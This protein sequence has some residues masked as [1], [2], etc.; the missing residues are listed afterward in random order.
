V[1]ATQGG[2]LVG[3]V[4]D[5]G[6][7]KVRFAIA[8]ILGGEVTLEHVITRLGS[9]YSGP[10]P[11]VQAVG[12]YFEYLAQMQ[13][14]RPPLE[15]I[16]VACAGLVVGGCVRFKMTDWGST[17]DHDLGQKI[18]LP[19]VLLLND[20]GAVAWALPGLLRGG[21]KLS[22]IQGRGSPT[23]VPVSNGQ[24]VHAVLNAGT[25]CNASA[26]LRNGSGEAAIVGEFGFAGFSPFDALEVDIF[27]LLH[28][29]F[30]RV[31]IEH[32]VCGP[33]LLN[34]YQALAVIDGVAPT[35]E[36]PED[37]SAAAKAGDPLAYRA[38][39]RF[40][41][42]MG[43]VAGDL[44]LSFGA[45]DGIYLAGG[46]AKGL[47]G[48]EFSRGK[49][50]RSP[51]HQKFRERFENKGLPPSYLA[52]VPTFL[53]EDDQ[54][55]LRGAAWALARKRGFGQLPLRSEQSSPK[56]RLSDVA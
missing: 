44:A 33:G 8:R 40:C 5:I 55:A 25:G 38:A 17:S 47:L 30:G 39:E 46:V 6:G 41:A 2:S 15:A 34:L 28:A 24:S 11:A 29:R 18:D 31:S 23:A 37:I 49:G 12:A 4:A 21:A 50:D 9:K 3:L 32:L 7:T 35:L 10:D 45:N 16:A 43:S 14:K 53:I 48:G 36:A 20:L 13:I 52:A 56:H 19:E 51:F 1:I 22:R 27:R 26:Y 54:V 42:I